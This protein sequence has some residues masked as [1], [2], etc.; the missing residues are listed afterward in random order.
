VYVADWDNHRIQV[1]DSAGTLLT[2][3]GGFGSA[4][5]EFYHPAGV[6]ATPGGDV[7][8]ADTGN[9][10]IQRFSADGRF[11]GSWGGRERTPA[12]A[13][14][15]ARRDRLLRTYGD[16]DAGELARRVIDEVRA[17]GGRDTDVY[18]VVAPEGLAAFESVSDSAADFQEI[19]EIPLPERAGMWAVPGAPLSIY[20][21]VR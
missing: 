19:A 18:W 13:L 12:W 2:G 20:R 21:L 9:G 8:V 1:F 14:Q 3:W 10:R 15:P 5:G 7:Y 11:I 17:W 16:L 4:D 6:A